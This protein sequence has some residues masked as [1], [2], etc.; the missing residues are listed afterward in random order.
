MMSQVKSMYPR[1]TYP[2]LDYMVDND[3][4]LDRETYLSLEYL[5]KDKVLTLEGEL[6]LPPM[7]RKSVAPETKSEFPAPMTFTSASFR[8]RSATTSFT[9]ARASRATGSCC[10]STSSGV[11]STSPLAN[12]P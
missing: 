10:N 3:M 8:K 6:E 12:W 2:V 11:S 5:D 4:P 9:V 1:G 7:F